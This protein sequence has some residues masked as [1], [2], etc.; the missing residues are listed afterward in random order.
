MSDVE[1]IRQTLARYWQYLDD[2][3]ERDWVELFEDDAVLQYESTI[4]RSRRELDVI[5]ADLRN[6][7]PAK[8]LSSNE[9]IEVDG[10]QATAHSDVVFLEPDADGSVKVRYYGRCEDTLR[11]AGS[12]WRFASRVIT[13]TGGDHS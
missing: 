11:R 9:L 10:E 4:T 8:H 12:T 2:R 7:T 3:R 13:F 5:A 6:Y 1:Q